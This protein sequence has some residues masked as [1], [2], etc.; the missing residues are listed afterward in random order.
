MT[1]ESILENLE[2]L[3]LIKSNS[4]PEG[5]T[6]NTDTYDIAQTDV[7]LGTLIDSKYNDSLAYQICD[8]QPLEGSFGKIFAS[9]RKHQ[10]SDLE[11]LSKDINV[12]TYTIN[13]GFT[14]EVIQD[15]NAMFNKSAKRSIHNIFKGLSDQEENRTLLNYIHDESTTLPAITVNDS[16][17]LESAIFQISKIVA[18]S[19]LKMNS[20]TYTSLDSFCILSQHFAAA[21]LGSSSF[22]TEGIEK[23]LFIGRF[24]KTS[25]YVNP[26]PNTASQFTE[27]Y[28]FS[29]ESEDTAT[30]D[31]CYVGLKSKTAG[32]SSLT[33]APFCYEK[34][35]IIDPETG[36]LKLFIRNRY[37]I[38]T[39]PLHRPLENN[40]MLHKFALIKG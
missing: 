15:M 18:E 16:G 13:T 14:Q 35:Y 38:S 10:S 31:Y 20:N 1:E 4:F 7:L 2:K 29:Y 27:D 28:D 6:E 37:G 36:N 33:F 3:D 30:P 23:S 25:F 8:V 39:S 9:A 26:F 24:G 21:F 12:K 22:M 17:N 5:L 32:R 40:S 11:V 19:V 34:E